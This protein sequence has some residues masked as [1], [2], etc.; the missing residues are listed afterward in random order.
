VLPAIRGAWDRVSPARRAA[1]ERAAPVIL[2]VFAGGL[3]AV[4]APDSAGDGFFSTAAQV[5]PVLLLA[6][7]IEA[8]VVG[9]GVR[10][11]PDPDIT[12]LR[13]EWARRLAEAGTV[14]A[15]LVAEWKAF[16]A[17]VDEGSSHDPALVALGLAWGFV[18]VGVLA[19]VGARPRVEV[20][21]DSQPKGT[22]VILEVGMGN[23]YGDRDVRPLMNLLVP[24]GHEIHP[25]DRDGNLEPRAD[26][27]FKVLRTPELIEGEAPWD[28]PAE[29][30]LLSAGDAV[31]RHYSV[32]HLSKPSFPVVLR[33]DHVDL[34]GGRVQRRH[35]VS[36]EEEGSGA[37]RS[38]S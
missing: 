22:V 35:V 33:L 28:Y 7:A 18:I 3:A 19:F 11:Q 4:C 30:V 13:V 14:L 34:P 38:D 20:S 24:G 16:D 27:N 36:P 26:A 23:V 6:L 25:C 5:L 31:L 17:I 32:A 12:A 10:R 37:E 21:M 8:R 2:G 15:L 29:R 1:V 9:R